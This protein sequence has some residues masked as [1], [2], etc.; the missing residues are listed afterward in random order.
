MKMSAFS[1]ALAAAVFA[2][3][4]M[5]IEIDNENC[6]I[7]VEGDMSWNAGVL[8][9]QM[10]DDKEMVITP[11]HVLTINGR[12]ID[13]NKD[14]QEWVATYYDNI[15]TAIPM[16]LDITYDA[17]ELA[18]SALN[19]A[20]G[21]LIGTDSGVVADID[22][23]FSGLRQE[24]DTHFYDENGQVRVSSEDFKEDGWLADSWEERF[25]S[26]VEDIVAQSTGR[27]LIAL[28]TQMLSSDGDMD[29]FAD[30]MENWEHDFEQRVEAKASSIEARADALCEVLQKADYAESKMQK[31]IA[32]LD[33]LDMFTIDDKSKM[34]M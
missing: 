9:V 23:L 4:T 26:Q 22:T 3:S 15:N 32:G 18:G 12:T 27:L 14:E 20:F 19:E 7:N 31:H 34:K 13:L 21:E 10:H 25:E 6:G 8:A 29:N 33:H 30:R 16:T 24:M 1:T 2:T 5:A 28:G 11:G 17:L